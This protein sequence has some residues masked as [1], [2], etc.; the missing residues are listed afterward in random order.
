MD[1]V[2]DI[3]KLSE[4]SV[5]DLAQQL[6]LQA[7]LAS[8]V[9]W[10]TLLN[11]L[12]STKDSE[13]GK[14][15]GFDKIKTPDEFRKKIPVIQYNDIKPFVDRIYDGE[16][17]VLFSDPVEAFVY[18][19]G[20]TG[21]AKLFPESRTGNTVKKII[22]SLRTNEI[23]RML[24]GKRSADW[25]VF[26]ITN[27]ANYETNKA[28]VPTGTA[29]GLALTQ[30]KTDSKRFAVPPIFSML[31][32]IATPAQ[33]YCFAFFAL[34]E[35]HVEQL[36]CNN[37]A[38][39]IKVFDIINEKTETLLNDI[40]QGSISADLADD[41][42]QKIMT[43]IKPN[44]ER[45]NELKAIFKKKGRFDI[46]DFWPNFVCV[47]CW[48]SSSVG[49][50]AKEYM[51]VFP[52]GTQFIH[53]GYGSSE[54]KFDVPVE[55]GKQNGIPVLFGTFYE[56]RDII[57]GDILLI[58]EIA[59]N[60]LYELI[61]TTYSGLYRYNIHD[62]VKMCKGDDG[63]PLIEFISKSKDK[64]I[65]GDKTLYAG[66][67][68]DMIEEYEQKTDSRIRLFQGKKQG[69]S[70]A[71]FIEPIHN[72]DAAQFKAFMENAF[73]D[74]GITLDSVTEYKQGYR[75]SLYE[76]VI[77]GKSVSSTKLPVFID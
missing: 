26:A 56:F 39:F 52:E 44:L 20:T 3:K 45:A 35:K 70:I 42:Q 66:Q 11:I 21:D 14:K 50:I 18:S 33:N 31:G 67:L 34:A 8:E 47:G 38:H 4:L 25:K 73:A 55:V 61:I 13:Y 54:A 2:T 24:E 62:L 22:S 12:D 32:N 65:L 10:Q 28:G 23:A 63:L 51:S 76:K 16:A 60:R 6:R 5:K 19:S 57:T 43:V 27:T 30:V 40:E 1:I 17:N 71:L 49:R 77:D 69:N 53:W 58:D 74:L 48:L 75:N 72:F 41:V 36:V 29:S 9:Q 15:F 37:V 7:G 68:A 64:L 59:E 46:S